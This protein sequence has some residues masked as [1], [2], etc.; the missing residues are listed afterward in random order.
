MD[1]L[2]TLAGR[3]GVDDG[4]LVSP[5]AVDCDNRLCKA[6]GAERVTTL[7]RSARRIAGVTLGLLLSVWLLEFN[8]PARADPKALWRIV[9]DA[10]VPHFEAGLGPKPCERVDLDGGGEAGDSHLRARTL[11]RGESPFAAGR[12]IRRNLQFLA[13][14]TGL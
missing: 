13:K 1:S 5:R 9:H 10:C 12:S 11:S 3:R 8:A 7:R 4:N 2:T 14:P 6:R